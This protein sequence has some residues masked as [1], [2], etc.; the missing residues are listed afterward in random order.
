MCSIFRGSDTETQPCG[1]SV[2]VYPRSSCCSGFVKM[3]NRDA[4]K[5]ECISVFT[6]H[7]IAKKTTNGLLSFSKQNE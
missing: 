3:L 7:K 6:I 4:R 1:A 2:C 5:F